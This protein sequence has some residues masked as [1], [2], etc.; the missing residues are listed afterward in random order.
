M[1]TSIDGKVAKLR[2][3]CD[4][5]NESKVRC[6]QA[7]PK[8]ARCERQGIGCIYGLSRRSHKS[9]PRIGA[10]SQSALSPLPP[11]NSQTDTTIDFSRQRN[12]SIHV[13]TEPTVAF[14]HEMGLGSHNDG[15]LSSSSEQHFMSGFEMEGHPEPMDISSGLGSTFDPIADM[16][17]ETYDFLSN[18]LSLVSPDMG[19]NNTRGGLGGLFASSNSDRPTCG[20]MSRVVKQL[21][22]IPTSLQSDDASFDTHLSILRGAINVSEDCICCP[23]TAGDEMSMGMS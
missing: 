16:T 3:S 12:G 8:C 18:G 22:S 13:A 7:K 4:A 10:S 19:G 23:C 11:A 17:A 1:I 5:C 6:S 15:S 20:C 9:A 21:L 2:A 14:Q